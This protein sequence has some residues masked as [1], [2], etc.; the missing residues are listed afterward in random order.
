VW[1]HLD[2]ESLLRFSG[3]GAS[4]LDLGFC[5]RVEFSRRF[6]DVEVAQVAI[7]EGIEERLISMCKNKEAFISVS[8]REP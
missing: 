3:V 4:L 2:P 5:S 7:V 8:A 6:S 1:Y